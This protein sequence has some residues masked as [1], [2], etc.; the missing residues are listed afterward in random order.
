[1]TNV[2]KLKTN[3]IQFETERL[4]LRPLME[5]DF[6]AL[7]ALDMDLEVRS[8]FPEGVL[9]REE[10][11]KELKRFIVEWE[12]LGFGIFAIIEKKTNRFM[13]R[14]GF[15]KLNTGEVEFGYLL[16]KEY[17]GQGY[18]TEASKAILAWGMQHI[19]TDHIVGFAP[20]HHPASL[21]VLEKCGMQYFKMDTY[22]NI[23]CAFYKIEC[24]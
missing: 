5:N 9:S 6:E 14:S 13:G 10:I 24:V 11:A 4:F 7:C 20:L 21:R 1:M 12:V 23:Q 18:A 19:P 16:L 2:I 15:A 3:G 8:Y 17:W 22:Q